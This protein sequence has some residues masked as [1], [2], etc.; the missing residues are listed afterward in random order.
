MITLLLLLFI[1]LFFGGWAV[2]A[3]SFM[4]TV[5]VAHA[6]WWSFMPTMGYETALWVSFFPYLISVITSSISVSARS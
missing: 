6:E 4:V 2:S 3:W 1:A 5:G